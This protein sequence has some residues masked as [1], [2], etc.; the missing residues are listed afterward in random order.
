M[1]N[2]LGKPCIF[3]DRDGVLVEDKNYVFRT[4]DVV[5]LSGIAETLKE[6]KERGYLIIVITNQSGVGRGYY[7]TEEM[8]RCNAYI[9]KKCNFL[10]DDFFYS[11]D[12][13][14]TTKSLSRKPSTLL[15]ERAIAIYNIIVEDSV[16]VGDKPTDLF[17]ANKLGI[18]SVFVGDKETGKHA[19]I[20][21][22]SLLELPGKL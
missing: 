21:V 19:D 2:D 5:I 13:P 22:N 4:E 20:I 7:S 6:L 9:N 16:M 14:D 3:L 15:F 18:M 12:D 11:P 17:P 8:H 10:I 1:R